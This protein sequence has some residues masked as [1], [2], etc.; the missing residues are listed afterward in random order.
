MELHMMRYTWIIV[1]LL[2]FTSMHAQEALPAPLAASTTSDAAP[3]ATGPETVDNSEKNGMQGNWV[4]KREWLLKAHEVFT[5]V[6]T[7]ANQ[8]EVQ[9]K[10]FMQKLNDI[11]AVLDAYYSQVGVD[12]GK[13]NELFDSILRFL[14][15]KR[16]HD[17]SQIAP[18]EQKDPEL[19]AKIDVVE[20]SVKE[21]KQQ[22]EQ[23]RLDMSA[24][25]ELGRSLIDRIKR[26]DERITTVQEQVAQGQQI[27]D[28]LWNII[29]HNKAR[30]KYYELQIKILETIKTEQNY[31]Q[32]DLTQDFDA[33]CE[34]IKQQIT[35]IQ[36]QIKKLESDGFFIKDRSKRIKEIKLKDLKLNRAEAEKANKKS[37]SEP[38]Q[39]AKKQKKQISIFAHIYDWLLNL[40]A[41]LYKIC[42][43][44]YNLIASAI[45]PAAQ[46]KVSS[47]AAASAP[48]NQLAG[49]TNTPP[50]TLPA[51]LPAASNTPQ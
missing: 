14:E 21:S 27:I 19:L 48:S 32:T 29:D 1:V 16:K 18:S 6:Q 24:I 41:S 43:S 2:G 22:L 11:D 47:P 5:E 51:A 3:S 34:T 20:N 36:E 28:D 50:P 42:T 25:N 39:L 45:T 10:G 31:I 15:K 12:E 13:I 23:L 26:V 7:T 35:S 30:D 44:M 37:Q 8:L 38:A 49:Q 40:F 17:V 4:K 9:R 33:V 46:P